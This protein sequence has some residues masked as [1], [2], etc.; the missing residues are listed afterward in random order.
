MTR[1]FLAHWI[2]AHSNT[3]KIVFIEK[4][5]FSLGI[6]KISKRF[7]HVDRFWDNLAANR[8]NFSLEIEKEHVILAP[9]LLRDGTAIPHAGS[10][11]NFRTNFPDSL[12]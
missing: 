11:I 4:S 8:I 3:G 7:T 1:K 10:R 5:G 2:L 6:S 9:T 12:F